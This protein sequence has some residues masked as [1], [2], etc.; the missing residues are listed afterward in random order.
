MLVRIKRDEIE[1]L[2]KGKKR[3]I[4]LGDLISKATQA[5]KINECGGCAKRKK[6]LNRFRISV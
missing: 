6:S 2:A 5:L 1:K 4:G 3:G